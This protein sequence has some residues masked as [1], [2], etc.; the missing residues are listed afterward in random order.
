M[1]K[2]VFFIKLVENTCVPIQAKPIPDLCV[3]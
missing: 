3:S 2:F 1:E